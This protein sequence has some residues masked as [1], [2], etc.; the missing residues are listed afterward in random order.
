[1]MWTREE[2]AMHI[3]RSMLAGEPPSLDSIYKGL[4]LAG[5]VHP[6]YQPVFE[7]LSEADRAAV[8]LYFLPH[9]SK[10][11][12]L[13]VTR[14]RVV[15]WYCPFADQRVFPSGHR[16][17]IN[18]YTGCEHHC[19]YC[20]VAG[21]SA[22]EPNCKNRFRHDLCKDLEALDAFDVPPAPVHL[23][24]STDP[25][26]PL[27]QQ[28]RHTLF[29][30]EK[31]AEHRNRF[32]TVTLLTKNPAVLMDERYVRVLHRLNQLPPDH[33]RRYWFNEEGHPPFRLECSL[34][35]CND[36]H[37][38]LL[39]PEAPSVESRMEALRFLR[40]QGLP[41]FLR[42]D[43]LFPRDPLGSGK[44]MADFR[45]PDVQSMRDL[46]GLVRFG[47]ELASP[48][49]I[50]SAAKITRPQ[51]GSLPPVMERLKQVYQHLS[52]GQPLVFHGGSW[53]LPES[54]AAALVLMPFLELCG[55]HSIPAQPCK[56]NLIT[57]P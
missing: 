41:I 14:P 33:P 49:I 36:E 40:S 50:Y 13:E 52:A 28:H 47:K 22:A 51:R 34:A 23:S 25:L 43:P 39:D 4:S 53:R 26:Q 1:M 20:Y 56:M 30:L 19:Q 15:K 46:E 27:E 55:R 31:L 8:A 48:H 17:C 18:V 2:I 37:R 35:F 3:R 9:G 42:I 54:V 5:R 32:T 12:A 24:N 10:K 6:K 38:Q 16:Y 44:T 7:K 29:V 11:E 21:Y 45:L 57:T